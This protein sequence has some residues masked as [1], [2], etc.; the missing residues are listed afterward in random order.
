MLTLSVIGVEDGAIIAASPSGER[1]RL[2]VDADLRA[3]LQAPPPAST[4]RR[5][6]PREIQAHVRA[7][8]SSQQVSA[9]TGA[10]V[11]YIER[12]VGPVLAEREYV[13]ETARAVRLPAE[14]E[15]ERPK[16]FGTV[17]AER[18]AALAATGV[19]WTSTK[20]AAGWVVELT[21][22]AD[23]VDHD[24]RWRFDPKRMQLTPENVEAATLSQQGTPAALTPRLR[25]LEPTM[26]VTVVAPTG[27]ADL[28]AAVE[29]P[30]PDTSRFDSAIFA[31]PD[32]R[33]QQQEQGQHVQDHAEPDERR[34]LE[35]PSVPAGRR[36][37]GP[38]TD[39]LASLSRRRG[40]REPSVDTASLP[41]TRAMSVVDD[42]DEDPF[43]R[44]PPVERDTPASVTRG[45]FPEKLPEPPPAPEP[46][47]EQPLKRPRGRSGTRS[48]SGTPRTMDES[49]PV[50]G[51]PQS[52]P[53]RGRTTMPSWDEIVFGRDED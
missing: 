4:E 26:P 41:V 23:G 48:T 34:R 7:G 9:L 6:S 19:R 24:A 1:Y 17:M 28:P 31:F 44:R 3:R 33:A 52:R 20:E 43:A 12:F 53:R 49:G 25:A 2:P 42:G 36:A 37:S 18:L 47:P 46:E 16:T 13:T 32:L 10:P 14:V 22:T 21:F 5:L 45:R 39:Q 15:G 11:A 8:L 51:V 30:A 38:T 35:R 29:P 50:E 40:E 27:P